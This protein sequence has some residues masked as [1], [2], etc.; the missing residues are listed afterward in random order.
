MIWYFV[1]LL[2]RTELLKIMEMCSFIVLEARSLESGCQQ[3]HATPEPPREESFP[4]FGRTLWWFLALFG[5][6]VDCC[7]S[8]Y[9]HIAHWLYFLFW[10]LEFP[11]LIKRQWVTKLG[12]HHNLSQLPFYL[13]A[14]TKTLFLSEVTLTATM[15]RVYTAVGRSKFNPLKLGCQISASVSM[16]HSF[17]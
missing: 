12:A 3:S 6:Q 9:D 15:V 1:L 16:L 5:L 8:A 17:L 13:L 10:L 11:L 2:P 14:F 4:P 7:V